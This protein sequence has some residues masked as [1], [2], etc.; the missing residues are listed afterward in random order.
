MNNKLL[1]SVLIIILISHI[2]G[3][4]KNS[5]VYKIKSYDISVDI[6]DTSEVLLQAEFFIKVFNNL[7]WT[8]FINCFSDQATVFF[9]FNN[10]AKRYSGRKEFEDIFKEYFEQ[11]KKKKMIIGLICFQL[12]FRDLKTPI[13]PYWLLSHIVLN[14]STRDQ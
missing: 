14:S 11:I 3:A 5:E 1:L 7:E 9:P 8:A 12:F 4:H 6:D 13:I 2:Q 10:K